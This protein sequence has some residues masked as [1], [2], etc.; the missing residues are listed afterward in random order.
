MR[1]KWRGT[2][3]AGTVFFSST[4]QLETSADLSY[5]VNPLRFSG[6]KAGWITRTCR[7]SYTCFSC[8]NSITVWLSQNALL[9]YF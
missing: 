6:F 8:I 3:R 5:V 1:H 2:F 4:I 7:P 9:M